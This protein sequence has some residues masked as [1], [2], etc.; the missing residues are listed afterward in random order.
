MC[1]D[2]QE[3]VQIFDKQCEAGLPQAI[4][5]SRHRRPKYSSICTIELSELVEKTWIQLLDTG[6]LNSVIKYCI[7][8]I[9][10][11]VNPVFFR[12][13]GQFSRLIGCEIIDLYLRCSRN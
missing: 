8:S 10:Y 6:S 2:R 7:S 11:T 4:A 9:P 5:D 12:G 1:G 3:A 13:F